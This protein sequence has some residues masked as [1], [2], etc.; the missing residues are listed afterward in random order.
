MLYFIVEL[1]YFFKQILNSKKEKGFKPKN[2]AFRG[3]RAAADGLGACKGAA[4]RQ[5]ELFEQ[6]EKSEGPS[7]PASPERARPPQAAGPKK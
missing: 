4:Q 5:T 3:G 7:R 6:S 1:S 2:S